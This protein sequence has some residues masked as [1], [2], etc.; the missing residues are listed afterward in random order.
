[1]NKMKGITTESKSLA[2]LDTRTETEVYLK[3]MQGFN[4]SSSLVEAKLDVQRIVDKQFEEI[5]VEIL[6][7]PPGKEVVL[8]PNKIGIQ[9]RGGIEILGRLKPEQMS[10]YVKYQTLVLDTTG[11]V[12]PELSLPQNV[13]LQFTK[14]NRLRYVIRSF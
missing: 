12:E 10:C 1:M 6:D 4:F 14:P 9:I 2:M 3:K 11:S 5:P 7:L 13:T 8:L